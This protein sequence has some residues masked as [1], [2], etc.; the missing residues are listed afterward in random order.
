MAIRVANRRTMGALAL[1]PDELVVYVGRPGPLGNPFRIGRDGD[2]AGVIAQ[3]VAWLDWHLGSD[4]EG[5]PAREFARLLGL[6][7][8]RD[9]LLV[10]HCAP[11]D[12]HADVI[13]ARLE[14]ALAVRCGHEGCDRDAIACWL[15]RY[16]YLDDQPE[17]DPEEP[18][19]WYC[20]EHAAL[21]GYCRCCGTFEGGIES[22]E[23]GRHAGYCDVCA[24][25]REHEE[26]VERAEDEWIDPAL[27]PEAYATGEDPRELRP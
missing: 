8:E 16:G 5:A 27:V 26:E 13:K 4:P 21:H 24:T 25:Q 15:P 18:D 14:D 22:F 1:A 23:F 12:C 9:L 11:M 20:P 7:R 10:C 2:R 19:D 3:F 6:A 17:N